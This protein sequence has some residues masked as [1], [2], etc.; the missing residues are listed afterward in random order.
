[1]PAGPIPRVAERLSET[2]LAVNHSEVPRNC[3]PTMTA[4][5]RREFKAFVM[6]VK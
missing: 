4:R 5:A 1:M 6:V 2:P 3:A